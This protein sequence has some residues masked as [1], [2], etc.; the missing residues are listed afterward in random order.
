VTPRAAACLALAALLAGCATAQ[1]ERVHPIERE[2][3]LVVVPFQDP[4]V[5]SR[6]DSPRSHALG[7]QTTEILAERA[8]FQVVPY[9]R[10]L[11]LART[12]DV[13]R[14]GL[15]ELATRLDADFVL[16]GDVELLDHSGDPL[17]VRA[18]VRVR[19]FERE[20][21]SPEEEARLVLRAKERR[22]GRG[23]CVVGHDPHGRFVRADTI[24][25]VVPSEDRSDGWFPQTEAGLVGAIARRVARLPVEQNVERIEVE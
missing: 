12:D 7:R 13:T 24:D 17:R 25:L 21:V 5:S 1:F 3:R 16:V 22:E 14:L 23:C 19:L 8:A 4:G 10:L 20:R 9:D 11:E 18:R 2:Q 15:R 6:W